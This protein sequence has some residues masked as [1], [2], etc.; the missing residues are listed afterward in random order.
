MRPTRGAASTVDLTEYREFISTTPVGSGGEISIEEGDNRRAIK[1]RLTKVAHEANL[2][3]K[4]R[5]TTN[6]KVL[7]EVEQR[8]PSTNGNG[9]EPHVRVPRR[10]RDEVLEEV[11]V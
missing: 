7:F 9:A 10:P 3:I 4:W 8:A 5:R 1:R 6:D 2:D 11:A